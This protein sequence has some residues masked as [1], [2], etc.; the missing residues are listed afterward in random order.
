[1]LREF[2]ANM[3]LDHPEL[4]VCLDEWVFHYNWFRGHRSLKGNAPIDRVV[5]RSDEA[6]FWD[7][8]G[9]KYDPERENIRVANYLL[10]QKLLGLKRSM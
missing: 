9:N 1:M 10:D 8:V 5:E 3:E 4:Q 6:P 2:Y 7:E